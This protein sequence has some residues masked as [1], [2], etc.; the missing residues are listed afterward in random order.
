VAKQV[1]GYVDDPRSAERGQYVFLQ[2]LLHRVALSTLSR[3]DRK[4]RHL[5]VARHLREAWGEESGEIADVMASHYLDAV[6]A[7]PDAPDA[8]EIRALA[9]QTLAEAGRR[10]MSLA[11]GPEARRHFERAAGLAGDLATRGRLLREAGHAAAMHDLAAAVELREAAAKVFTEAGMSLEAAHAEGLAA[12]SMREMGRGDEAFERL[13]RAY[14]AVATSGDDEIVAELASIL[15]SAH[16]MRGDLVRSLELHETAL[17]RAEPRR[18]ITIVIPALVGKAICLSEAGRRVEGTALLQHAT[19]LAEEH[20]L[21]DQASRA[22]YNLADNILFEGRFADAQALLERGLEMVRRRGDRQAERRLLAQILIAQAALGDWDVLLD[23]GAEL[24]ERGEDLWSAQAVVTLPSVLMARGQLDQL[25]SLLE[26]YSTHG[27]TLLEHYLV[28]A[29]AMLER[30]GDQSSETLEQAVRGVRSLLEVGESSAPVSFGD[31]VD[32]GFAAGRPEV[33]RE[34]TAAVDALKPVQIGPALDAEAAR[35]RALLAVHD[36]RSDEA[37]QWFRRSIDLF[38]ELSTPFL[39][40]RAQLQY[41]EWLSS[42]GRA[43]D[44]IRFRDEAAKLFERLR[45]EPWLRRAEKSQEGA[46][47]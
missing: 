18:L 22:Q 35:A 45:A 38:R 27:W 14:G 37:E 40:A 43:E 11:S 28:V 2:A 29:R 47:A 17:V 30:E 23:R 25:R 1:L 8:P 13:E 15:A 34:L 26:G 12:S 16:Q 42:A 21:G 19:T 33:V 7:E 36:G 31:L 44:A 32:C 10:A 20:D 39:L 5:T 6:E 24:I 3:R 41:A 4:A 9:C 46:L